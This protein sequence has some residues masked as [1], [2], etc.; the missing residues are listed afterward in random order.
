MEHSPFWESNSFSDS[1]EISRI[2]SNVNFHYRIHKNPPPVPLLSQVYPVYALPFNFL[3]IHFNIIRPPTS[4][5]SMWSLSFRFPTKLFKNLS[6]PPCV[7]HAPRHADFLMCVH[8]LHFVEKH[9]N[10]LYKDPDELSYS[11]FGCSLYNLRLLHH[12]QRQQTHRYPV[13]LTPVSSTLLRLPYS[14]EYLWAEP[15]ALTQVAVHNLNLI[16]NSIL[17]S[18]FYAFLFFEPH[19][20]TQAL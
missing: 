8:F 6:R 11:M 2:L 7:P 9:V 10:N 12:N 19:S 14:S 16:K 3:K 17:S 20:L 13:S 4:R 5:S 18:S 15:R 1:Q